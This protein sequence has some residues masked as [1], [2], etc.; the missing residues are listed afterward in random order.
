MKQFWA[1]A[2]AGAT[3]FLAFYVIIHLYEMGEGVERCG[4]P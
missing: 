1:P 4:I 3:A 2:S